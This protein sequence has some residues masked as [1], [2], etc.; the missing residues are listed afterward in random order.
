ML[1]K[2]KEY[3]N[4]LHQLKDKQIIKVV[5]GVR[6]SGK[7]TLFELYRQELI[8]NGVK[9]EQVQAYNFEDMDTATDIVLLHSEI[10]NRL[11]KGEKNYIFLDEIQNVKNWE[12]LADSL[13]IRDGIDLYLTGSN[14][15]MLSGELATLLSGRYMEISILPLS[16]KEYLELFEDKTDLS[17]KFAEYMKNGGFPQAFQMFRQS[18]QLGVDY[19]RGI[20]TTIA[21]KD[22]ITRDGANDAEVLEN[23]LKFVFQNI[24]NLISPKNTAFLCNHRRRY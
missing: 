8:E 24:G 17:K 3:L 4:K 6:R 13:F 22:V 10:K 18:D 14:A 1:I 7:S 2:R 16:F 20:Y 12:K 21:L 19:L 5:T 15:F 23:I 9:T 11:V